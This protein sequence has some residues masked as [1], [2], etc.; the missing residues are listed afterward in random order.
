MFKCCECGEVFEEAFFWNESRGEY[1]GFPCSEQM[2]GCPSCKGG[3]EEAEECEIC[4]KYFLPTELHGG[5][6]DEC[7]K[8]N[9][10]FDICYEIGTE[11]PETIKI[12]GFLACL[13]SQ[14]E[15]EYILKT[16]LKKSKSIDCS[17]YIKNDIEWFG[18]ELVKEVKK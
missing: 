3:F 5:V 1:W 18:E 9:S 13:F 10:D 12:N 16:E 2:S 4:G 14:S 11:N 15:I 8:E 6:C 17:E 7:I